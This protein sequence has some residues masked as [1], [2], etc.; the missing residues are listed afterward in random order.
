ASRTTRSMAVTAFQL[1]AP[2]TLHARCIGEPSEQ[3]IA[4]SHWQHL[5]RR[6][7]EQLAVGGHLVGFRIDLALGRRAVVHHALLR[8]A[9]AGILDCHELLLAAEPTAQAAPE[10]RF[11]DEHD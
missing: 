1:P 7:G 4:L 9:A 6:T 10:R 5:G 3:E 2:L 8:N 11:G